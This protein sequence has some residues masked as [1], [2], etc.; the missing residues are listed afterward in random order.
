MLFLIPSGAATGALVSQLNN[1]RYAIW[2]GWALVTVS[3]GL[4]LLWHASTPTGVWVTTLITMGIGHGAVLNA[5]TFAC[6]ALA[7]A[8]N[9]EVAAATAMYGFVRQMGSA[10]GVSIGSTTWQNVAA[11]RLDTQGLPRD[12]AFH[13]EGYVEQLP[14]MA[15][16]VDAF[17][18]GFEGVWAVL[19]G[20]A[21]LAFLL[22]FAIRHVDMHQA[23][24]GSRREACEMSGDLD[25]G[26]G[27]QSHGPKMEL[28]ELGLP[29][30]AEC[31]G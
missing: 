9:G 26:K 30:K 14:R 25:S 31:L 7:G 29:G 21:G 1:F 6:Q 23:G 2:V 24:D 3:C 16:V 13:A 28:R 20:L 27:P 19:L 18:G 8:R 12:V 22:G 11:R 17:T 4:Q 10:V 15:A 5:Q